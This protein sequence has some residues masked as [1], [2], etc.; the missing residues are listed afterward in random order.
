MARVGTRPASPAGA[1][2][3]DVRG[4]EIEARSL[5]DRLPELMI[6]ARRVSYTVSA[7]VHGRRRPGPGETFWQFRQFDA[8]DS[9]GNIDWRRSASSDLLFVR[10]REWE[11]AHTVWLWL[12]LSPSMEFRSPLALASKQDRTLVLAFA[13]TDLLIAAGERVGV[14]GLLN[15]TAQRNA[16]ERLAQAVLELEAREERLPGL[17]PASPVA[18]LSE[19][20]VIGDLLDDPAEI[21]SRLQSLASLGARGHLMQVLDP[22][23]EVLPYDGR[24]EFLGLEGE[25][26]L[27]S[28]RVETLRTRYQER[29]AQH[30]AAIADIARRLSWSLLAHR[31]DQPPEQA[32]LALHNRISGDADRYQARAIREGVA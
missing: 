28:D 6:E 20:V 31:T 9:R 8:N 27:L 22:A 17:P 16:C 24:T 5:V 3:R 7:G 14:L 23:E 32:L 18:R 4:L 13:L 1:N 19:C 12:D 15:P 10:E 29:L 11:A 30:R 26:S 2:E 25:E 21:R